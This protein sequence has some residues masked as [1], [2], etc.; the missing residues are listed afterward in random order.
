MKSPRYA[1]ASD[2]VDICD[3]VYVEDSDSTQYSEG[4]P[5]FIEKNGFIYAFPVIGMVLM[6][7]EQR[8]LHF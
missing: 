2:V 6:R 3:A 4:R 8:D 5:S 1:F 7:L